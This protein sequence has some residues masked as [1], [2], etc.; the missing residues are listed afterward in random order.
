ML[1]EIL[2]PN[3]LR[4]WFS[5]TRVGSL[6][7]QDGCGVDEP[8][9]TS[10][11]CRQSEWREPLRGRRDKRSSMRDC[12]SSESSGRNGCNHAANG[13]QRSRPWSFNPDC[14]TKV[15]EIRLNC[16]AATLK[17]QS[18]SGDC[19]ALNSA[20]HTLNVEE[21][22]ILNNKDAHSNADVWC[23]ANNRDWWS[24]SN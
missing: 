20:D 4:I 14:P 6:T 5:A 8:I 12:V 24:P 3:A 11:S 23:S 16:T 7:A 17:I 19:A 2:W 1:R 22:E 15:L 9:R 10:S 21:T 13:T 18:G